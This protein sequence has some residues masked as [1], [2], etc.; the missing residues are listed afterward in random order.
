MKVILLAFICYFSALTTASASDLGM[1]TNPLPFCEKPSTALAAALTVV[2]AQEKGASKEVIDSALEDA[3]CIYMN[4]KDTKLKVYKMTK[5]IKQ[6][7]LIHYAEVSLVSIGGKALSKEMQSYRFW[8]AG[9]FNKNTG[10]NI[11][12]LDNGKYW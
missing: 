1:L 10:V 4:K 7:T 11:I 6:G 5:D 9:P 3:G 2:I 8:I 12:K